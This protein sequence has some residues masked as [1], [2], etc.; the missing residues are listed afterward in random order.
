MEALKVIGW[1]LMLCASMYAVF[2]FVGISALCNMFPEGK[3]GW[4]LPVQL[5]SLAVFA[6]VVLNHPFN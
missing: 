6:A 1:L 3:R 5:V 4:H 2:L